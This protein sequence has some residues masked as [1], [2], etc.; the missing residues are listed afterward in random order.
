MLNNLSKL[1]ILLIL[2]STEARIGSKRS[3]DTPLLPTQKSRVLQPPPGPPVPPG[4][5]C[6]HKDEKEAKKCAKEA[7][8]HLPPPPKDPKVPPP[9]PTTS[10]YAHSAPEVTGYQGG[11]IFT[12]TQSQITQQQ[13]QQAIQEIQQ[14]TA[15]MQNTLNQMQQ[16]TGGQQQTQQNTGNQQTQQNTGN[17][18]TQ[19]GNKK[20]QQK[21]SSPTKSPT[22]KKTSAPTEPLFTP[23]DE[24]MPVAYSGKHV[25]QISTDL[26]TFTVDCIA[27]CDSDCTMFSVNTVYFDGVL[28]LNFKCLEKCMADKQILCANV[29][30][31]QSKC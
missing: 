25:P 1:A 21:S 4:D 26:L 7:K 14:A 28:D 20:N 5:K 29:A 17:Q 31:C 23:S 24:D 11:N 30:L 6:K 13:Q 9:P 18:K 16:Q 22:K 10:G 3:P 8:D 15:N 2:S 27:D 12:E 19:Y